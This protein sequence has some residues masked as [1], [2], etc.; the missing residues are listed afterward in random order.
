MSSFGAI[1]RQG[2]RWLPLIGMAALAGALSTL[3]LPFVLGRAVDAIVSG[4]NDV[5]WLVVLAGGLI[6]LGVASD[7]VDA[8]AGTACVANTSAWLRERLVQHVLSIGP[9]GA[10]RFDTG[11]LVGRVSG[12]AV[13]AAHAGPS[14][15]TVGMSALPPVGSLVLLAYMDIWLAVA[16]LGGVALV[17]VVLWVF[18]R[19]TA[20]VLTDYQTTLGRIAG[21]LTESLTG[22]R[23]IAAAGTIDTETRRVLE[24]LPALH[25]LGVRTWRVLA[26]SAAQSA[27]VGP[28]VLV[29]VL[30]VGGFG[31][32]AGRISPGELFAATQ[33][34]MIGAGLG[35]LTGVFGELARSRAGVRRADELLQLPAVTYGEHSLQHSGFGVGPLERLNGSGRREPVG[36]LEFRGV[37]VSDGDQTLLRSVDLVV[38]AGTMAAVVGRSGAGKSVLAAVAARLCD[39]DQGT[40][41]LDGIPLVE[42]DHTSLRSAIG[43]AFERPVLVGETLRDVIGLGQDQRLVVAAARA[44]HAHEFVSRL[45]DG[46]DTPLVQAPMS[47]GEAQRLG[48]ARSWHAE[49]LLVLDDATS[50]LDT[51][52][53]LRI[54]NALDESGRTQLVVTH[55]VATA[56]KA[57]LVVWLDSGHVREIGTHDELW[58]RVPEY[59]EVFG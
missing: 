42:L 26:R 45:P 29:A 27:I 35:S 39:P 13:D 56:A 17:G 15:V 20:D 36:R 57:D 55:R 21:R 41:L 16:F 12:S 33:Y 22:A 28:F 44:T 48:V 51:I 7:L 40:V 52:T 10:R 54:R 2:G 3:A 4:D 11:D 59:R 6:A 49:R 43:C 32:A 47:G 46:Y 53:E 38:P 8:F 24:H 1:A 19:R 30:T 14:V 37:S 9:S 18:T 58:E 34:A 5:A 25:A 23:T 31:L 50:S